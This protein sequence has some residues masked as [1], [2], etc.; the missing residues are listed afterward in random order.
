MQPIHLPVDLSF[1][2]DLGCLLGRGDPWKTNAE[3]LD[4]ITDTSFLASLV[5]ISLQGSILVPVTS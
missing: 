2:M 1:L 4:M 3:I 5:K